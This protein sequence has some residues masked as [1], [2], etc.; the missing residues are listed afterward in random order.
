MR[1]C[2]SAVDY[3]HEIQAVEL[4]GQP[5]FVA[6]LFEPEISAAPSAIMG[7]FVAACQRRART[8]AQVAS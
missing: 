3:Q 7:A 8:L 2:V 1:L 4:D 5:F 6:T